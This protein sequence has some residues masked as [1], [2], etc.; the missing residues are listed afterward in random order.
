MFKDLL[1]KLQNAFKPDVDEPASLARGC[2]NQGYVI[3]HSFLYTHKRFRFLGGVVV[4]SGAITCSSL[5]LEEEDI[6]YFH[7][8]NRN[9]CV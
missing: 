2:L 4:T 3:S 5:S 6:F 7:P 9:I 8:K 1:H